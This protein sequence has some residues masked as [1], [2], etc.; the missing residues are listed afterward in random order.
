MSL[1]PDG[2]EMIRIHQEFIKSI[3]KNKVPPVTGE[4]GY[5]ALEMVVAAYQSAEEHRAINLPVK[6]RAR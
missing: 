6:K 2:Q 3:E 4:D 5:K 1:K